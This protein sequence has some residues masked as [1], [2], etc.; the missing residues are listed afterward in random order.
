M[1]AIFLLVIFC[2]RPVCAEVYTAEKTEGMG[3]CIYVA[4]SP[5]NYPVEFYDEDN[6]LYCGIIPDMLEI[7]SKR[8][9][10]DFVYINGNKAEKN[11]MGDNLQVEIVSSSPN[12]GTLPYYKDY[13]ELVSFE[14]DGRIVKSGLVFT[15]LAD[16]ELISKTKAAA[17][18]IPEDVKRG[19]YLS[20]AEKSSKTNHFWLAILLLTCLL[21]TIAVVLLT[22]RIK[23]IRKKNEADKMTDYETGMGNLQF[24]K[25]HF[26]Y[27]ISDISRS[28]YYIA[29]II[30]DSS[31]LRS[32][33][34]E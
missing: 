24:F 22:F 4:G 13:L 8:S 20:Y 1:I 23:R 6:S 16:D 12:I 14:K 10:V 5:D 21:L 11:I 32:Y 3:D 17:S 27:T 30:L 19:I 29:Y 9:G 26:R 15:S 34:G 7:I 2:V 25:Y 33:H 31:Y 18:Y 28:L